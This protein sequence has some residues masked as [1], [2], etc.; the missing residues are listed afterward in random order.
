MRGNFRVRVRG[1]STA[2][3][4]CE[5]RMFYFSFVIISLLLVVYLNDVSVLF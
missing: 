1:Q 2:A 3:I 4:V 5:F